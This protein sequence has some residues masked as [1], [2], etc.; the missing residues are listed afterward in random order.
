MNFLPKKENNLLELKTRGK[1]NR[2]KNRKVQ[3]VINAIIFFYNKFPKS[4]IKS[5]PLRKGI[6]NL[7]KNTMNIH[8]AYTSHHK[9]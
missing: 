6:N 4:W 5:D 8:I 9:T 2:P 3:R 7:K 1:D